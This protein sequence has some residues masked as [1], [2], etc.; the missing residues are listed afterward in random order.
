MPAKRKQT[1]PNSKESK[2]QKVNDVKIDENKSTKAKK[3]VLLATA[4]PAHAAQPATSAQATK[5]SSI[6]ITK[7]RKNCELSD[8]E[9]DQDVY[10][11]KKDKETV[12]FE[13]VRGNVFKKKKQEAVDHFDAKKLTETT[14]MYVDEFRKDLSLELVAVSH[15]VL[16]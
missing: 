11:N 14:K 1:K 8:S 6:T 4:E 13:K 12:D 3:I 10:Y 16:V 5:V 2:K 9:S 15:C 7:K